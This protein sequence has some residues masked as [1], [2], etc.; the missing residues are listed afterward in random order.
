MAASASRASPR[1][2]QKLFLEEKDRGIATASDKGAATTSGLRCARDPPHPPGLRDAHRRGRGRGIAQYL[3]GHG[4][5][6]GR[7]FHPDESGHGMARYYA[8]RVTVDASWT[9]F[10]SARLGLP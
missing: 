3:D 8:H 2:S 9:A 6:A 1:V 5:D 7:I 10:L 4:V